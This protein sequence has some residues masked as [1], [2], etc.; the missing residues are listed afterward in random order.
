[1][2]SFTEF[3]NFSRF[4]QTAGTST[5]PLCKEMYMLTPQVLFITNRKSATHLY[6]KIYNSTLLRKIF[7]SQNPQV[8][9]EHSIP[10]DNI[11]VQQDERKSIY[12]IISVT[13]V[14]FV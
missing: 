3:Q 8:L 2:S 11:H 7:L 9:G 13:V 6:Q 14:K 10:S 4:F 1:V 5:V 12:L